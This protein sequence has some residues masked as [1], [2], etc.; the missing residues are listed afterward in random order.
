[1]AKADETLKNYTIMLKSI[2]EQIR[3]L[4]ETPEDAPDYA[5]VKKRL[6]GLHKTA[7]DITKKMQDLVEKMESELK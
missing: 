2:N 3:E 5:D 6:S 4:R 7:K 1:M